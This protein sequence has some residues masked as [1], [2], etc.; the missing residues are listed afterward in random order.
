MCELA[1]VVKQTNPNTS[2]LKQLAFVIYYESTNGL[3]TSADLG[4]T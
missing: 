3:S 1:I 2:G 4:L